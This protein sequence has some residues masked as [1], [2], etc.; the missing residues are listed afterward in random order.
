MIAVT[1]LVLAGMYGIVAAS[2]ER[3]EGNTDA[4][5]DEINSVGNALNA[6]RENMENGMGD[7]ILELSRRS[8]PDGLEERL[9]TFDR[10]LSIWI[11]YNFPMRVCGAVATLVSHDIELSIGTMRAS[12]GDGYEADGSR[13]SCFRADGSAVI[14]ITTSSGSAEY[15]IGI[16]ADSMSALPMLLSNVG[17]FDL[18]VTGPWSLITGLM[19]YQLSSL[20]QYRVM[21]G[22]GAEHEYGGMGTNAIITEYDVEL[23]YRIALSIAETTYLRT[24]SD[25]GFDMTLYESVDAAE[26]LAFR[27]GHVEMDLSAVLAQTLVSIADDLVISWME[28]LM[29]TKVLDIAEFVS[30]GLS[31]VYDWLCKVFTGS[32]S[33]TAQGYLA[34]TMSNNGIPESGYRYLLNGKRGGMYV[35]EMSYRIEGIGNSSI[36]IPGFTASFEYPSVD[37]LKWDGWNGFMSAYRKEHNEIRETLRGTI[38]SLAI[39]ISGTY[40]LGVVRIGCDAYDTKGFSVSLTDAVR[41]IL[42]DR[43]T[44]I[45]EGMEEIIRNGEIADTLYMTL[46]EHMA[47]GRNDLFGVTALRDNI[48]SSVKAGVTEGIVKE[49]GMP[50]DPSVIDSIT[51]DVMRSDDVAE[52]MDRYERIVDDRILL[53]E[54]V[55]N[56]IEKQKRSVFKDIIMILMRYGIDQTGLYPLLMH[57]MIRLVAD[58]A[59]I[60]S[61]DP[62][63]GVCDLPGTDSFVLRDKDGTSIR[64]RISLECDVTLDIRITPPTKNDENVHYV[65]FME[66]R[67]ASYSSMYRIFVTADISY[68]ATS[69]S[70]LMDMLGSYDAMITGTSHSEFDIAVAVMSGWGLAG[71]DYKVSN[72]LLGDI[73]TAFLKLI[74]PLIGPLLELVRLGKSILNIITSTMMR[75][76]EFAG[77]MIMRLYDIIMAPLHT[78]SDMISNAIG[79]L[80]EEIVSTMVLTLGSQTFGIDLYGMRLEIITD[81]VGELKDHTS[82]TKLR[83]TMPIFGV[84]FTA[85]L[86]LKKDKSSKFFL[87]GG[88]FVEA[89]TWDMRIIVDP[90]MKSKKYML[91]MNGT[92]RGTDIHA[93]M[94]QAVQYDELEFRLSD[95]PGVG[96]MLSNIPLPI[97]GVKGC[98][99]AGVELK[100]NLPYVYGVVINEFELNPKG[101][102]KDNEWVEL[103]NSTMRPVDLEGYTIV[104]QSN[105]KKIYTIHDIVLGP[106]ER[107][108]ITFPGQ[109]LNNTK[110]VIGLY[111]PDGI[112]VDTTPMKTDSKNDEFTWQRETDASAKWVFKKHTKDDDNGG[113]YMG[114][115]P[116]RAALAQCVMEASKQAFAELGM[117][118]VGPDGVAMFLKRTVELTIQKAIEMI[119]NCVV[120]ASIFIE[121]TLSDITGSV[122]SGIRFSLMLDRDIVKDGLMWVVG[123]IMGMMENM[124]NPTGMTPRQIISDDIYFQTMLFAQVR[125][126]K[127]LG[128]LGNRSVVAGLSIGCNIT[129]LCN[130]FGKPGG[131][132]R[133]NAGIVLEDIP[134]HMVPPMIKTDPDKKTDLWLFRMTLERSKR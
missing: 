108:V 73:L 27:D 130:L 129:A 28:Y 68:R 34:M 128:S 13:P 95:V 30:D 39:G 43:R 17:M 67:G 117:K 18:A 19:S 66:D 8:S 47:G 21:S 97:P 51:D 26:L 82:T 101:D 70:P 78:F 99:D 115:G 58:T 1:I 131:T 33:E 133:V 3:A 81:L 111:D 22:Y 132:W 107:T 85:Q 100:Y 65:G 25:G 110:E 48:R 102:D 118:L 83:L 60:I 119:A 123:Q 29:L 61:L 69:I 14:R 93:V 71:V 89:E 121:I 31:S 90:L 124:D 45:E 76:A 91:E 113:K 63:A 126:P 23:A 53:F 79:W 96:E 134:T 2:I 41:E 120:S 77:E 44:Y 92:F 114:G 72:T 20:A 62:M 9:D 112:E 56:I 57:K 37:V 52:I 10:H 103:Y 50:L 40:G 74:E 75:A 122:Q 5:R 109:F 59:E 36:V 84:K 11:D 42:N 32:E 86:D 46:C 54:G 55:S 6:V 80:F 7:M 87:S 64:E 38:H 24:T 116:I 15:G 104:P 94:P 106:G 35:P 4:M 12:Q 16:S 125:T 88:I 127:I 49:Y 98:L 105:L